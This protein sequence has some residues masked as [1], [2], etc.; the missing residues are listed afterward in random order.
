MSALLFR[1]RNVPDDEADD[2]RALLEEQRVDYYETTAGNWGISMPGIWVEH[3]TDLE[4][5]RKLIDVYQ[6]QRHSSQRAEYTQ[7]RAQGLEPS[8]LE[9]LT[10]RPLLT[11]AVLAFCLFI[12]Y[13]TIN[14]FLQLINF[15]T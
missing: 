9:G 2:I 13:V 11:L 14:P 4:R 15:S 5:A 8:L 3:D 6:Q 10:Q 7:R 12:L 1:L